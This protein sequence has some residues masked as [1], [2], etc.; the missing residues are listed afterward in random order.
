MFSFLSKSED[1]Q[2]VSSKTK[3]EVMTGEGITDFAS[4]VKN[5][6]NFAYPKIQEPIPKS[7]LGYGT[8]PVYPGF[9]P[10][11]MDG[12]TIIASDQPESVLNNTLLKELNI[13]SNWQYRQY[14]IKNAEDIMKYNYRESCNDVGYFKRY[15]DSPKEYNVPFIYPSFIS[16]DKPNG[17]MSSDLKEY[18]LSRE[19]LA[20]RKVAPTITQEEIMQYNK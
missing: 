19:Q 15:A 2:T 1:S 3:E 4:S 9:P 7:T 13:Q 12:R 10:I 20:A 6:S 17:Y 8:N 14:L 16:T 5:S 18:Y 11:M